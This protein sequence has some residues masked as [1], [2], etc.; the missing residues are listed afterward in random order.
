MGKMS[1]QKGNEQTQAV[2]WDHKSNIMFAGKRWI[3]LFIDRHFSVLEQTRHF[4]EQTYV[5][6]VNKKSLLKQRKKMNNY[7]FREQ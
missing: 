6:P 5:L 1:T 2:K 4:D 3:E 7:S